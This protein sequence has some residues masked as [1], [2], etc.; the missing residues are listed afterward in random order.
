MAT[1]AK[2]KPVAGVVKL[3]L[4]AGQATP[5]P[6]V[7]PALAEHKINIAE[8]CKRFND[9]TKNEE[10]GLIIPAVITVYSD[11]SFDF[12]LKKPP[13]SELLKRAAGVS[14]GSGQPNTQKVGKITKEQL[15]KI[16]EMKMPDMNCYDLDAAMRTLM[17]TARN[18]GIEIVER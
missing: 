13:A 17:G 5:A 14:A 7:G 9:A 16:A 1:A 10:K 8:F 15:R 6:P 12:V 3:Q 18:M 4:P 11:R 2:K